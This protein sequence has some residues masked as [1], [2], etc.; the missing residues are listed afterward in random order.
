MK[1]GESLQALFSHLLLITTGDYLF[2][3]VQHLI[4]FSSPLQIKLPRIHWHPAEAIWYW[5]SPLG[6]KTLLAEEKWKFGEM[7]VIP[8]NLWSL[9]LNRP[10]H[11]IQRPQMYS[12]RSVF[13]Y[14]SHGCQSIMKI[15]SPLSTHTQHTQNR[16][17][18][19]NNVNHHVILL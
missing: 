13:P 3:L 17:P 16:I 15:T 12:I 18:Y 11:T 9:L 7:K 4:I 2:T 14:F 10:H 5:L 6:K 19:T 8:M 1:C